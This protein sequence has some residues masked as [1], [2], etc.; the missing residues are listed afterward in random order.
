MVL[1]L[2]LLPVGGNLVGSLLAE[3]VRTPNWLVGAALHAAA[4]IAVALVSVDLM[5][6][7][8]AE[9]PAWI[10]IAAFL[11]GAVLSVM[12]MQGVKALSGPVGA[13]DSGVW[14]A[15]AA[16]VTD[17]AIDGLITGAGTGI[18]AGLGLLLAL[19]QLVANIPGGFASAA[20]F[21]NSGVDR[22]RRVLIA[23][24]VPLPVFGAAS[25]GFWLLQDAASSVQHAA[26]AVMV[27]VLLLMTVE[28][29]LPQGD[30]PEPARWISTSSFAGGFAVF[31]FLSSYVG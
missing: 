23:L 31:A 18:A 26:L 15:H 17:L 28:D 1:G 27:G 20:N 7:I 9:T 10:M 13:A 3:G 29:V 21:R 2:A 11:V 14:M 12:L 8:L 6:R 16:I 4:G 5:P 22:G 30:E 25:L 24:L 19:S